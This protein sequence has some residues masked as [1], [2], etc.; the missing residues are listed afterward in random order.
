MAHHSQSASP[1]ILNANQRLAAVAFVV[2]ALAG[3]AA[4]TIGGLVARQETVPT[5]GV[6]AIGAARTVVVLVATHRTGAIRKISAS[7]TLFVAV[8]VPTA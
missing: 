8:T 2:L 6:D 3:V 4:A 1:L 7:E 5:L